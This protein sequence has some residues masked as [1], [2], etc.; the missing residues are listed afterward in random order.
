MNGQAIS[1]A[2]DQRLNFFCYRLPGKTEIHFGASE[3]VKEGLYDNSFIFSPFINEGSIYSIPSEISAGDL[4][5]NYTEVSNEY[6]SGNVAAKSFPFPERSTTREQHSNEI[7]A[8][9]NE[10]RSIGNGK[11]IAAC[12][13]VCDQ[14]VDPATTF[15]SLCDT[16]PHAFIFI[17]S[18]AGS[19]M[20]MG[21]SPELLLGIENQKLVTMSLAGTRWE[22]D[23]DSQWDEKN[24]EEQKIVTEFIVNQFNKEKIATVVNGPFTK[25]AGP[26]EH[27]CSM[28]R[29]ENKVDHLSN[30]AIGQL[31][32]TL[33]PTPALSGF[34]RDVAMRVIASAEDFD[35]AYYGGFCGPFLSKRDFSI[36]VNLR[37]MRIA[38]S[39]YA[40]FAGGGITLKSDPATEWEETRRKASALRSCIC[41]R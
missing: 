6:K 26:V 28:I 41:L 37:S 8:I 20:W 33:S 13:I 39:R 16:Y 31:L 1:S 2:I 38:N 30:S 7:K 27:L 34:P 35:R 29:S 9:Q 23:S 36:F 15:I 12:T 32:T 22:S 11:I 5:K 10:L 14:D 21:A 24:I 17:F 3:V 4:L 40:L 25:R 19:G 18:A